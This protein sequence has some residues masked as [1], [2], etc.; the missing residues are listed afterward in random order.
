MPKFKPMAA[1]EQFADMTFP[2]KGVDVS[3]GFGMQRSGTTPT[4][5]NVRAFEPG[6]FRARGGQ[7]PG[8]SK[9]IAGQVSGANL[10]QEVG[11]TVGTKG[12]SVEQSQSGRVVTL[13]AVSQGLV[14][15]VKAGGTVWTQAALG[16]V[17]NP[18]LNSTGVVLSALNNQ[19]LWFADGKHFVYYDPAL[20][21]VL[22]WASTKGSLPVDS[23]GNAPRL[24]ETWRGRTIFSGLL[25][26]PQNWF[27]SATNDPT[28][29]DYS[30]VSTTP[31]Q[32]I[33]GN[34]APQGLIGDVVT[35]LIP[36]TD[37]VM[38]MGGDHT[39]WMMAGDPMAGGQIDLISNAIGIAW[40]RAWTID[41]YN[42]IFFFGNRG[43]IYLLKPGEQPQR[44]SQQ[45]EQLLA[46]IDTGKNT[47]RLLWDDRFQGVHVFVTL[48]AAAGATTHFF[49]EVRSGAWWTDVFANNNHN[50][51]CCISFDGNLAGDRV[52]LIGSWDGYV[53]A[54]TP[55]AVDD[56]GTP[57][58]SAVVVGPL[59]TADLD[60]VLFK[61]IQALLG[62]T[63]G[64]V[65]Y[66]VYVG[67]T[68][69]IALASNPVVSG[70]WGP[71]RNFT[72]FIRSS[73]H[74]IWVKITASSAWAF[75]SLR[76]RIAGQGKV[77]RRG[78]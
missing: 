19:L 18:P 31:T 1:K 7:R 41:P 21:T 55:T 73:G 56:D 8:S 24:I 49:Y 62:V 30:P 32:A 64:Q 29:W 26:D 16:A 68:A 20:N 57:I 43:G 53:R 75:E 59:L 44:I 35:A 36:F 63:S 71:G 27:M 23:A 51:L 33:A 67:A 5:Q 77:R 66:S 28:N 15:S 14:F 74:A 45:I 76:C 11:V 65:T 38:I 72:N 47:I 6:T 37:D 17:G 69:E 25:L 22:P 12:V 58:A 61:D 2:T 34:N 4:G 10:V 40:G 60:D 13:V 42:N 54:L 70:T 3:A 46:T 50:P 39:I 48:T 9:Y 52:P 78:R